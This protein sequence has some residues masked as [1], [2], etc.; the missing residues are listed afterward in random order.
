MG[1]F[2][3]RRL[4]QGLIVIVGVTVVVFVVTRLIGDPVKLM[5][6]LEATAA[7]RTAFAHAL[8]LD[9]PILV[10]FGDFV[11]GAARLNFGESLW[12]GRPAFEIIAETIP[13]TMLLVAAGMTLAVVVA[14]PLGMIASLKPGSWLDRVLVG[15]SL[16]G[17]SV[18]QFWLGL[19][20]ILLFGVKLNWLPT[21]G[22]GDWRNVVLP[23]VT[24]ALPALGRLA[25]MVRSSMIDELNKQYIETSRAKG[26]P[27]WR[28]VAVHAF[29]NASNPV[30]TLTG[31]E[32]IRAI[33]GYS[34]V[35]E[36]VFAWPGIGYMA[37]QAIKQQDLILL[38]AIVFVVATVVV[39]VNLIMDFVYKAID[40]RIQLN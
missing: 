29:R 21:A 1:R 33:A 3:A 17:L 7:E 2:M 38:Q 36:T 19:M 31:W 23:A 25:M 10:Q 27:Y 39:I 22:I 12:Q 20:L 34:V 8:G 30:V 14:I 4:W 5:L 18:P 35:V 16:L 40:P 24:L 26:M 13:R 9:R 15:G 37:I 6:P 32:L 28:T 11:S